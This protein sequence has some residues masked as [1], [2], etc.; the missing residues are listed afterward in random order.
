MEAEPAHRLPC[1]GWGPGKAQESKGRRTW[2]PGVRGQEKTEVSAQQRETHLSCA[3]L[4]YSEP[5]CVCVWGG[6]QP[7]HTGAGTCFTG[8]TY[9]NAPSQT[10]RGHAWPGIRTSPHQLNELGLS[11]HVLTV[12]TQVLFICMQLFSGMYLAKSCV[13]KDEK[14]MGVFRSRA[15]PGPSWLFGYTGPRHLH[16][17][18]DAR[19]CVNK[20]HLGP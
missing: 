3:F 4:S 13:R 1:A 19:S 12:Q 2:S 18:E 6:V 8:P 9:A 10:P 15:R 7:T 5:K 14:V 20:R 11:R 16:V 17:P